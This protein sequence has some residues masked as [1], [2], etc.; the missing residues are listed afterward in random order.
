ML[1]KKLD[2]GKRLAYPREREKKKGEGEKRD[3]MIT[4]VR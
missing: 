1:K 2:R 4:I 3:F